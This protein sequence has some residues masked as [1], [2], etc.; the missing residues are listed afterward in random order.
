MLA[1]RAILTNILC[2][3]HA[4][5]TAAGLSAYAGGSVPVSVDESV[6]PTAAAR[7]QPHPLYDVIDRIFVAQGNAPL[8]EER[9]PDLIRP[10]LALIS[11][12]HKVYIDKAKENFK[13][14]GSRSGLGFEVSVDLKS[15]NEK[16]GSGMF[17]RVH[18]TLPDALASLTDFA[19]PLLL[20][21]L[22]WEYGGP[23]LQCGGWALLSPHLEHGPNPLAPER[24]AVPV[25]ETL[26]VHGAYY[27]NASI[28]AD[29]AKRAAHDALADRRVPLR[30]GHGH[31]RH[32]YRSRRPRRQVGDRHPLESRSSK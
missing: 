5:R 6:H 25:R 9:R 23:L 14:I 21:D 3:A 17:V 16:L 28:T 4:A 7:Q 22:E 11:D 32:R 2:N 1:D 20:N 19:L 29:L 8:P 18:L 10:Y 13:I 31:R 27:P 15:R 30:T 24:V 26:L 12:R